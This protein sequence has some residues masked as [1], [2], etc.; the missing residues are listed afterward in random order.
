MQIKYVILRVIRHF[1][2]EKIARLLLK[3]SI[4]IKPGLETRDP[5]SAVA[6]YS[7]VLQANGISFYGKRVLV[8]GYGGSY[9]IGLELLKAGCSHVTLC[10][11][12]PPADP[13][14]NDQ[15][16]DKNEQYL[17]MRMGAVTPRR[18]WIDLIHGDIRAISDSFSGGSF[19]LIVSS[20][21]YEH[22]DDVD[23]I[24]NS[25]S[26]LLKLSGI[27]IAFIDLRDHYFTYPFEML[28]YSRKTWQKWLNPSSNLNRFRVWDYRNV[29]NRYFQNA[30]FEILD[31]DL[32]EFEKT[33]DR[34]RPEFISGDNSQDAVTHL[35][36]YCKNP[37]IE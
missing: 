18:E 16:L 31:R 14:I 2:P 4:F 19:D 29:I 7:D 11:L 24:T 20:S 21:V 10:D 9:A 12:Y 28:C 26:R 34:I 17:E 37:I 25:L 30:K 32:I 13:H 3:K 15:L 35:C 8:F 1:M 33:K 23:G 27:M 22:L 36:V 5:G 6:R